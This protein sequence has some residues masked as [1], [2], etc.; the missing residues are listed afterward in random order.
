VLR[1]RSLPPLQVQ[2]RQYRGESSYFTVG[3]CVCE[4]HPR[5][6]SSGLALEG[7]TPAGKMAP[8]YV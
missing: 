1:H 2:V 7:M 6:D 3:V 8:S 4:S 5:R